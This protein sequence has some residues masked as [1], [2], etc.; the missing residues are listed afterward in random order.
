M[1]S[2]KLKD[3]WNF[4]GDCLFIAR[5]ILRHPFSGVLIDLDRRTFERVS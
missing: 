3:I 4:L 2:Q 5:A 1:I